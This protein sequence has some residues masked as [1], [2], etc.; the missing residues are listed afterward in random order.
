[1]IVLPWARA[2]VSC[3]ERPDRY[4]GTQKPD[5]PDPFGS[6]IIQFVSVMSYQIKENK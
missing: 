2:N 3:Q 4:G 5:P 6:K 1:M